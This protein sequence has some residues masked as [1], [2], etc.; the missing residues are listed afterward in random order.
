M[1]KV[2]SPDGS[3]SSTDSS[4]SVS[5]ATEATVYV[6]IATSFNGFDKNPA[7][8][9]IDD[10]ALALQQL[11]QAFKK[12]YDQI[13]TAHQSDYQRFFKRVALDFGSTTASDLPTNERLKDMRRGLKTKT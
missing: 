9:G 12:S 8:E 7:T 11:D 6:T 1:V 2:K 5:N 3:V 13:Q 10:R 4:L